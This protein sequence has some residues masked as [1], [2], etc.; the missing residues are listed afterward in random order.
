MAAI[1]EF[2]EVVDGVDIVATFADD[3]SAVVIYDMHTTPFGMMRA[4]E[5]LTLRDG[6]IQADNLVFDTGSLNK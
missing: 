2:A 6:L 3:N 1:S 5:Y 4:S